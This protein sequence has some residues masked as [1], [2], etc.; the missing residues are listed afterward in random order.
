MTPF[1]RIVYKMADSTIEKVEQL[2]QVN[3]TKDQVRAV[4]HPHTPTQIHR[5]AAVHVSLIFV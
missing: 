3:L 2:F 4:V 5:T 1:V